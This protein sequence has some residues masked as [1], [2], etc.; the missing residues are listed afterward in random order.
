[1]AWVSMLADHFHG[2]VSFALMSSPTLGDGLDCFLR[3][4]PARIPYMHLQ[5]RSQGEHFIAE[6]CPLIELGAATALAGRNAAAHCAAI[7]SHGV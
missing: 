4:F 1:M 5:G 2:P 6:I 3:Y 7:S